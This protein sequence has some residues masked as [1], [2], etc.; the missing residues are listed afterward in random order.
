MP[1]GKFKGIPMKDVP[2]EYLI[3]Y[4]ENAKNPNKP[5]MEYIVDNWSK[6]KQA[7]K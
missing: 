2:A 6:L 5:L 3:W 1:L 4:R 7:Q